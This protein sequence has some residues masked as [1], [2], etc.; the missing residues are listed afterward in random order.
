[1]QGFAARDLLPRGDPLQVGLEFREVAHAHAVAPLVQTVGI[2]QHR[3]HARRP[4]RRA[5]RWCRSRRRARPRSGPR[6]STPARRRKIAGSGFST[7]TT[8]ESMTASKCSGEADAAPATTAGGHRSSTRRPAAGPRRAG[9]AASAPPRAASSPTGSAV[10]CSARTSARA[11]ART[12]LAVDACA[13]EHAAE[14]H[15]GVARRCWSQPAADGWSM[16]NRAPGSARCRASAVTA[17]PDAR[18]CRADPFPV[19]EQQHATRRR[20]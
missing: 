16:A 12:R 17:M 19:G 18:H 7:P 9:G 13:F 14:V 6:P 2:E 8:C 3:Q 1:M 4:A 5:R 20:S 15:R 10:A 11:G